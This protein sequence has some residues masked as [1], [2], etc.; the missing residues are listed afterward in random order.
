MN[1]LPKITEGKPFFNYKQPGRD[2][3]QIMPKLISPIDIN[4]VD[5]SL[6]IKL[7]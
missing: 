6:I 1:P 2:I 3:T 5:N 4:K 7:K